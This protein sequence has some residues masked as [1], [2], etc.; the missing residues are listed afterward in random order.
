MKDEDR[1]ILREVWEGRIPAVFTLAD[2]DI[3]EVGIRIRPQGL[4]KRYSKI[5]QY[6]ARHFKYNLSSPTPFLHSHIITPFSNSII[7]TNKEKGL[8]F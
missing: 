4:V 7:S 5:D 3:E 8:Y 1:E 2:N 6:L